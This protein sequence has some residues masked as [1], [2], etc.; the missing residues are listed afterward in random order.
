MRIATP[1]AGWQRR[2]ASRGAACSAAARRSEV[3]K[4]FGLIA[5]AAAFCFWNSAGVAESGKGEKLHLGK[6]SAL[7]LRRYLQRVLPNA[8]SRGCEE[9]ARPGARRARRAHSD[10]RVGFLLITAGSTW[11]VAGTTGSRNDGNTVKVKD[12]TVS[13]RVESATKGGAPLTGQVVISLQP[14]LVSKEQTCLKRFLGVP[15][16]WADAREEGSDTE[17]VVEMVVQDVRF[18]PAGRLDAD[19]ESIP[20]GGRRAIL[21]LTESWMAMA[22]RKMKENIWAIAAGMVG[23]ILLGLLKLVVGWPVRRLRKKGRGPGKTFT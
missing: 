13:Y 6:P 2:S 15:I 21:T 7:E 12:V 19:G 9:W 16:K 14:D 20:T 18:S 8:S 22:Y 10:S 3:E 23:S 5:I 11:L 4:W 1:G 17:R